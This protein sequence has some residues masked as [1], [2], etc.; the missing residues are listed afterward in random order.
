MP[1]NRG[2][3]YAE[4]RTEEHSG[5]NLQHENEHSRD[6]RDSSYDAANQHLVKFHNELKGINEDAALD[7][8]KQ[9]NPAE[10]S[11]K[12]R[13]EAVEAHLEA[14]KNTDWKD[15][16]E[17]REAADDVAQSVFQPMYPRVNLADAA[18]QY[19]LPDKFI[20]ELKKENIEYL[21]LKLDGEGNEQLEMRAKDLETAQRL[22]EASQG[23]FQINSTR[24][25]DHFRDQFADALY[26]GKESSLDR[27]NEAM[28]KGVS[29][30]EGNTSGTSFTCPQCGRTGDSSTCSEC[31]AKNKPEAGLEAETEEQMETSY[32]EK[33][34]FR[35]LQAM[36]ELALEENIKE[37]V[38]G[39]LTHI[40]EYSDWIE[41][42]GDF[43][44]A[45]SILEVNE[46][47]HEMA[48]ECIKNSIEQGDEEGFVR[49]TRL[50]E[51]ASTDL[52][53]DMRQSNGFVESENYRMPR[54]EDQDPDAP[55]TE[56]YREFSKNAMEA[57]DEHQ[58]SMNHLSHQ[59][60]QQLHGK[61]ETQT[62]RMEEWE[63]E[64]EEWKK[65]A[66]PATDPHGN[67]EF[68]N[69]AK[70]ITELT[71]TMEYLMREKDN[72]FWAMSRM[73]DFH[74]EAA[75]KDK[76]EAIIESC[77][78]E[79]NTEQY[80]GSFE[81]DGPQTA[82]INLIE[83]EAISDMWNCKNM[84]PAD[85]HDVL[86]RA[87][88]RASRFLE[89]LEKNEHPLELNNKELPKLDFDMEAPASPEEREEIASRFLKETREFTTVLYQGP[90][91]F[92]EKSN[93]QETAMFHELGNEFDRL[94]GELKGEQNPLEWR[95]TAV[96]MMDTAEAM[97]ALIQDK[98][99]V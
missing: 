66:D 29:L 79:T 5:E 54:L 17:R 39:R 81:L 65:N 74:F 94:R 72:E 48:Q 14:F 75:A 69:D 56:R 16:A 62:D 64:Y 47:L 11:L 96:A 98:V 3:M 58:A 67:A 30:Y 8:E 53:N 46:T 49:I 22:V 87:G 42:Q 15:D 45:K 84:T 93:T 57:A 70:R 35:D 68:Q 92:G 78:K 38:S 1:E 36:D 10:Y 40:E 85:Y 2:A 61:L 77:L 71:N 83:R 86:D 25:L 18:A 97:H 88:D 13:Q 76:A 9:K 80:A 4:R 27:M 32:R 31:G 7:F 19:Q 12:E 99:T 50:L 23:S 20:E 51:H 82:I 34:A 41:Q 28:E 24:Q 21:E 73:D 95:E 59:I 52:A 60:M 55:S 63:K 44:E 26:E 90:D 89:I 43:A 33:L 37:I 91:D 6:G